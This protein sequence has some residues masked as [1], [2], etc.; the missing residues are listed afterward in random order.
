MDMKNFEVT[1]SFKNG[2]EWQPFTKVISAPNEIQ[3]TESTYN[4]FGSKH[5][6]KRNYIKIDSIKLI[7]GE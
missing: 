2:L 3:A 1:G 6:L 5:R 7:N 4:V